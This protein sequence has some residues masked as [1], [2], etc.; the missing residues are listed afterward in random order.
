MEPVVATSGNRPQMLRLEKRQNQA[1][2]VAAGCHRSPK[3]A[4][5]KQGVDGSSPSEGFAEMPAK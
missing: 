3:G 5:G 1:K 2:T 4:H